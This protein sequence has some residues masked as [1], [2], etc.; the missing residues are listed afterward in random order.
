MTYFNGLV[1]K[2]TK[3]H[4]VD[5]LD[6]PAGVSFYA[7]GNS[8]GLLSVDAI[9]YYSRWVALKAYEQMNGEHIEFRTIHQPFGLNFEIPLRLPTHWL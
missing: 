8:I 3:H 1:K 4:P 5:F 9:L 2:Q 7:F 6:L